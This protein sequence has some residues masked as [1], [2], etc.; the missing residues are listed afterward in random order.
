MPSLRKQEG[1]TTISDECNWVERLLVRRF[2][3]RSHGNMEEIVWRHIYEKMT[4]HRKRLK[5]VSLRGD[6][7]D[8]SWWTHKC[9]V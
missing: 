9:A 5:L 2:G 8:E 6:A 7:L 1:V 4:I 3:A